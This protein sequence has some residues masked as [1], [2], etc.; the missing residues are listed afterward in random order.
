[1]KKPSGF[2]F[3]TGRGEHLAFETKLDLI[4]SASPLGFYINPDYLKLTAG[5]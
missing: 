4:F 2:G 1:M 5:I 3:E